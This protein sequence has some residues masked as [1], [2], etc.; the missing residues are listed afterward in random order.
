MKNLAPL[1]PERILRRAQQELWRCYDRRYPDP[2]RPVRSAL[3]LAAV[4]RAS[5]L[6][7]LAPWYTHPPNPEDP[8]D[9]I[10]LMLQFGLRTTRYLGMKPRNK[11]EQVRGHLSDLLKWLGTASFPRGACM[12]VIR[13]LQR[14]GLSDAEIEECLLALAKRPSGRPATTRPLAVRALERRL[15]DHLSWKDLT[16][17]S[18]DCRGEKHDFKCRERMRKRVRLLQRFLGKHHIVLD[19]VLPPR[20]G[21]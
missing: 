4:R 3:M 7:V 10:L 17:E 18:C 20:Q 11:F 13:T 15:L 12:P 5:H 14:Q 21:R 16:T 9:D 6:A 19:A 2:R 8:S 1:P